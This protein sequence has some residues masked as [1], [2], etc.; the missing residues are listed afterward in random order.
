MTGKENTRISNT[1]P[2]VLPFDQ[3]DFLQN[4][5]PSHI[6]VPAKERLSTKASI[7]MGLLSAIVFLDII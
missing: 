5:F 1:F 7:S 2:G 4:E 6:F 3:G